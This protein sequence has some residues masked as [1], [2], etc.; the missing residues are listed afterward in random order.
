MVA[1][2]FNITNEKA[3]NYECA[4]L[5]ASFFQ[6]RELSTDQ[7]FRAYMMDGPFRFWRRRTSWESRA[8]VIFERGGITPGYNL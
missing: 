6:S 8:S 7:K 3:E 1:V 4:Q 5:L 2:N